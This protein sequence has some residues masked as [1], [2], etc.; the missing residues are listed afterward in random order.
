MKFKE[1]DKVIVYRKSTPNNW[2]WWTEE[3]DTTI[4]KSGIIQQTREEDGINFCLLAFVSCGDHY[5]HKYWYPEDA[6]CLAEEKASPT[7]SHFPNKCPRCGAA[8]Y[9]G[10]MTIECSNGC[11]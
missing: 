7:N 8:A 11:N 3:Q 4:G 9:I 6:L 5:K 2:R 1:G 10:L